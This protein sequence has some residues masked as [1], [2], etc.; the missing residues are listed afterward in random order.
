MNNQGLPEVGHDLIF[1][2]PDGTIF[3]GTFD[4]T[5]FLTP[6]ISGGI[7]RFQHKCV[8]SWAYADEAFSALEQQ[9][10]TEQQPAQPASGSPENCISIDDLH[11]QRR[12]EIA[13]DVLAARVEHYGGYTA[14]EK[15]N[16]RYQ[17]ECSVAYADALL[18]ELE[19][20]QK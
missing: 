3:A 8:N 9:K 5:E 6:K 12:Y 18:A 14:E 7:S 10:Q 20:P 2:F 4:G 19:K 15:E 1:K 17:C 11:E 13:R 16:I